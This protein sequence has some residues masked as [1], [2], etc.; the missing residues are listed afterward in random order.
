M[1]W[2]N[3]TRNGTSVQIEREDAPEPFPIRGA[4]WVP[5]VAE[6]F[7]HKGWFPAQWTTG[8]KFPE[9]R[10]LDLLEVSAE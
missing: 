10:G 5:N 3:Q 7:A 6:R 8:G 2:A 1:K 4:I 9:D